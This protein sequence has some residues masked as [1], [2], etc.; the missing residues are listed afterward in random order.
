MRAWG[1][2]HLDSWWLADIEKR[3][4]HQL[5]AARASGIPA[6]PRAP[7]FTRFICVGRRGQR[8]DHSS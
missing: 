8:I 3:S 5:V 2:L 1:K 6:P 7:A 4:I